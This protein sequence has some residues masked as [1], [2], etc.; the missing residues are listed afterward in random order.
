MVT[1]ASENIA[2]ISFYLGLEA[3]HFET[4]P[5]QPI[6]ELRKKVSHLALGQDCTAG[7]QNV[8]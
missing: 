5:A 4:P 3:S 6:L 7:D 2:E 1:S 8:P